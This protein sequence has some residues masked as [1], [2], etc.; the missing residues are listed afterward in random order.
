MHNL[1]TELLED[2]FELACTDGGYTGCSLSLVSKHIR[3]LS[4]LNRFH[5]I[6]LVSGTAQQLARFLN[7]FDAECEAARAQNG[8]RTPL[9]R[10]LC[11]AAADTWIGP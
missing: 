3:A 8:G 10:H 4:R 5:S 2:I 9:V 1:A 11:I 7:C 6:S